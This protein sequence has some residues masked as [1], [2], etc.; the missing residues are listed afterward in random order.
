MKA[1]KQRNKRASQGDPKTITK[2]VTHIRLGETNAGKLVALD[3]LAQ[4][5]LELVQQYVTL[6]CTAELPD[7]FHAPCFQTRLS[8]RW[9]RVAIQQAAGIAQSWRTNRATAYQDYVE[10]LADYQEQ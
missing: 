2:A 10:A 4:V 6:F 7:R 8:E 1:M 5:F 3:T 9:H